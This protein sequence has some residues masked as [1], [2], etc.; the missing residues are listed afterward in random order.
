[1]KSRQTM[2][3]TRCTT[4]ST[5]W[6]ILSLAVL[7]APA[8][9]AGA[10]T[11]EEDFAGFRI[12]EH[13]TRRGIVS[14]AGNVGRGSNHVGDFQSH[15]ESSVGSLQ[16]SIQGFLDSEPTQQFWQIST[17]FDG[18]RQLSRFTSPDNEQE[19]DRR[20]VGE[21]WALS[22]EH[23]SYLGDRPLA[24][25]AA[26]QLIGSYRQ[27]WTRSSASQSSPPTLTLSESSDDEDIYFDDARLSLDASV[28]RVRD[29]TGIYDAYV[30]EERL[31]ALGA[32]LR[33]L[34]PAARQKV[35]ALHYARPGYFAGTDR[36]D[37]F[38]WRDVE[39]V[40]REDGALRE[41]AL[42]P[43]DLLRV[44]EPRF[45]A[46]VTRMRGWLA[47]P[48]LVGEHRSVI[49]GFERH[50]V[51]ETYTGGVLTGSSENRTSSRSETITDQILPGF[52]AEWHRPVGLHA[53]FDG[54]ARVLVPLLHV[55][56]GGLRAEVAGSASWFV[57]ER[58]LAAASGSYT[59]SYQ[60]G[61]PGH[62][63]L[64]EWRVDYGATLTYF[65][66]DHLTATLQV[67][68]TQFRQGSNNFYRQGQVSLGLSYAFW[69]GFD[70]PGLTDP[71]RPLSWR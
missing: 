68:E 49:L 57:E 14:F 38:F 41:G 11:P 31:Q 12:P 15:N 37:K 13:R 23:R 56:D 43:Y 18:R 6:M 67:V 71:V 27:G 21:L 61:D 62:P 3:P 33:P 44:I 30:L 55:V 9:P 48:V 25:G 39:R 22:A 42:A 1:M 8:A 7:A 46:N 60:T 24:L 29:A 58:W 63:S 65:V 66:Q 19:S 51:T 20:T 4:T 35:A 16:G 70:A 40:L 36:P 26:A 53:Q 59:D 69:R 54:A 64:D 45:P 50:N 10:Q 2:R 5:L 52:Q 28:G 34:S 32:L 17:A 47:G